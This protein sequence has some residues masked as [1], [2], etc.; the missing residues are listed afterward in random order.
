MYF[1][2]TRFFSWKF[3]SSFL[4]WHLCIAINCHKVK[5]Q[6][7]MVAESKMSKSSSRRLRV[8]KLSLWRKKKGKP[9]DSAKAEDFHDDCSSCTFEDPATINAGQAP[10]TGSDGSEDM[11]SM[12]AMMAR[13]EA[14]AMQQRLQGMSHPDVLFSLKHLARAHR[15]RGEIN[16]SLLIEE[17]IHSQEMIQSQEHLAS[18]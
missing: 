6:H 5:H 18:L 3:V 4:L 2:Q 17:M 16:Q 11:N 8:P 1:Y 15:R 7:Q 10:K 12:N 13:L 14:I 9:E